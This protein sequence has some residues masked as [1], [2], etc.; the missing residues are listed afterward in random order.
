MFNKKSKI[1]KKLATLVIAMLAFHFMSAQVYISQNF[2]GVMWPPMGWSVINQT[3]NWSRSQTNNAGGDVPEARFRSTPI[4]TGNSRLVSP[5]ANTSAATQLIVKFKHAVDHNSGSYTIGLSTR[6]GG[7]SGTWNNVWTQVVTADVPA[8]EVMVIVN[9]DDVGASNFQIGLFFEGNSQN[10]NFWY[11]DDIEV[12]AFT[13][14]NLDAALIAID[15]PDLVVGET[16]VDGKVMNLGNT[17]INSLEIKWQLDQGAINTTNFTGL[18]LSTGMVYNFV[19]DQTINV[20]PGSYLLKVWIAKVNGAVGDD[21]PNNDMLEKNISVLEQL[22]QRFPLFEEFTSSTCPPC[23]TFNNNVMNP[24]YNQYSQNFAL[25]KYQ[26]NWPGAGDPYYTAEGGVR[27]TYYGVNAVPSMWIEGAN[28]GLNWGAVETAYQNAMNELAF[29][30][31]YAQHIID[32]D[33]VTVNATI[34]PHVTANNVR[35]HI[36]VVEET[37]YGNVG[38]NGETSFKHVMMKMLPNAN[39][40]LV[41][42]V[43]G[44]PIELS[45]SHD[46]STTFVEEMDDLLVVVFVQDTDKSIFQSAYSEEVTSFILP[47]DANCDGL[48]DVLDVVA[49]VSYALGNNPQPFCFDNADI[50]GD[51]VIDVIDVV[52]VV[53]IVLGGSK[54][55]NIPIKSLPAHFF[56]NEKGINFE[57]DGTVAGLQ[58]DLTGVEISDLQFMLQGYEFAVSKQEGQ[59]TG[60]VFSFDNTPLPAGKVEL[61]RFNREPINLHAGD[62]VAANVNANPVKVITHQEGNSLLLIEAYDVSLYPNPTHGHFSIEAFL[63]HT[64]E[65]RISLTD[66]MGREIKLIHNGL[67]NEGTHRFESQGEQLSVGMYFLQVQSAPYAQGDLVFSRNIKLIVK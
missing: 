56:L 41:N 20:D 6:S 18:N 21:N 34:I 45:Y 15:V 63:P 28:V 12:S 64:S 40:T 23:A 66:I 10:T 65:T 62:I 58:F 9:N 35:A 49:T 32:E 53:N 57:S 39:G 55:A 67:L 11:I 14:V 36:V 38:T 51:G 54:S 24:F 8:Q 30:E 17:T 3:G 52:G 7:S 22:I 16:D 47:G 4:F 5:T 31:I 13:P 29:M 37:T 48:I 25:I 61:F 19:C 60:I 33:D 27:R 46:M 26:M 42:L 50:N 2:T 43:A 1:M 59:L 44:V